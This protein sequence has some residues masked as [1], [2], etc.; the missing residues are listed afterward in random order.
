[1]NGKQYNIISNRIANNW[2]PNNGIPF[3]NVN[4]TDFPIL[5]EFIKNYK[6]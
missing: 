4:N 1:M 5:Y 3:D 6:K 2:S